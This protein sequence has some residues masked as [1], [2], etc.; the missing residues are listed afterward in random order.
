MQQKLGGLTTRILGGVDGRGGGDG[1]AVVL[2][3]G[4]GAP[5]DDLVPLWEALAAPEGTRFLFPEAPLS[6]EAI[7][8]GDARAWWMINMAR[9]ERVMSASDTS[10]LTDEIPEGLAEARAMVLALIDEAGARLNVSPGRLVLGGFSQGAMLALDAA[11]HMK[12]APAAL[13]L[14]SGTVIAQP[15]WTKLLPSRAGLKVFQSH[16]SA[17]PLLPVSLAERLREMMRGAGLEVDWTAFYGGHEIPF[18][19]LKRLGVFLTKALSAGKR[20]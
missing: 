8:Y 18:G 9:L 14:L 7:G 19:V 15:L 6:M 12:Q 17:D 2:L 5:G 10:A 4:F 3:H 20:E 1:P 13:A 16:G 11:L